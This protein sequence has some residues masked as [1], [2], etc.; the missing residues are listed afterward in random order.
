M[1]SLALRRSH[2]SA[3][4]DLP[5]TLQPFAI[6]ASAPRPDHLRNAAFSGLIYALLAAGVLVF[7]AL[8]PPVALA[9]VKPTRPERIFVIDG[10]AVPR[11]IERTPMPTGTVGG[12]VMPSTPNAV[13]A[14]RADPDQPAAGLS[15]VDHHGDIPLVGSPAPSTGPTGVGTAPP[16]ATAGPVVHD[17][18]MVGLAVLRRVDPVYPDFA[19]RA[20]IQGPVVLMMT[21]DERGQPIQVQ[22]LEGHS[23]FHEAA[24]QAARQWRFEPARVD[25]RPVSAAFRLTL[26]FSLR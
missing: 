2:G 1:S 24:L 7:G 22:V 14:T 13:V 15:A 25:G 5:P 21:V 20:R 16:A 17:F 18:S 9:Q 23:A 8:A 3:F 12:S 19:R 11:P 6:A 26:K 4:A 10:P